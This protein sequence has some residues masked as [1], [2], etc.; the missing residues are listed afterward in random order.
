MNVIRKKSLLLAALSF[1]A[2]NAILA[3]GQAGA[4]APWPIATPTTPDAQRNSLKAVQAQVG[5]LQNAT[6]TAPNNPAGY[7]LLWQQFQALRSAYNT[8]KSTLTP[9]QAENGA[10][11]LAE[12]DAALDIIQGAF[13]G[14]QGDL[15]G[16]RSS[17]L[18]LRSLCQVLHQTAALWLQELNKD[19]ARLRVG[20]P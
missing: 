2:V 4:Q 6:R 20:G 12:L 9:R 15:S 10:N 19:S 3:P 13:T 18:A 11:E 5:W 17:V 8:F 14:Y 1:L 7:D 16:G